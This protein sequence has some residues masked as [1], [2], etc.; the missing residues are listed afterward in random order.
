MEYTVGG[1][2]RRHV[3]RGLKTGGMTGLFLFCFGA[4]NQSALGRAFPCFYFVR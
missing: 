4:F 2:W 3:G 1:F